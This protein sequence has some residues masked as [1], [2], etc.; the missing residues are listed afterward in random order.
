MTHH[1]H[2]VEQKLI[3]YLKDVHA[4]EQSVLR[5]LDSMIN[6]TEDPQIRSSLERHRVETERHQ[7]LIRERLQAKG[8]DAAV[9]RDLPAILGARGKG[10]LDQARGDKP[11]RNARDGFVT[12]HLEIAS[13]ELLERLAKRAHDEDTA[14]VARDNRADEERMADE[15]ASTWDTVVD[16]TLAEAG[17]QS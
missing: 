16:L 11:G 14:R 4:M 9:A 7:R 6:T 13:Y 2:G 8:E 10:V 3:D 1:G 15:I 17:V 5:M 12:E